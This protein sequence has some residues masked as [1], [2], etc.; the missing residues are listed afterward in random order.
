MFKEWLQAFL[1]YHRTER[2]GFAMLM[3]ALLS[4]IGYNAYLRLSFSAR[5]APHRIA[6][7]PSIARFNAS[8]PPFRAD[9]HAFAHPR[10]WDAQRAHPH[11]RT[12]QRFPFNPNTLDSAGWVRLGFSPRQSASIL[13]YRSRGGT[14]RKSED[15]L[16]LFMVDSALYLELQPFV[17]IP[18]TAETAPQSAFAPRYERPAL[19]IV[20][21]NRAD[22]LEMENIRGIGTTFARRIYRYRERLGGFRTTAQLLEVFGMD[23]ARLQGMLPQLTIDTTVRTRI[24]INT[25]DYTALIRHPYLQKNQVRAIIAYRQQHGPFRSVSDLRNIHIIK[26]EDLQRLGPYLT[27][28]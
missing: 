4:V 18:P 10:P 6:F 13:R 3:V 15:L 9:T 17:T 12:P 14:F 7:G 27:V 26:E 20:D 23:S 19:P 28:H 8:L 21:I 22:T 24:N 11:G 16:K 5:T 2:R 25:A 1:Q